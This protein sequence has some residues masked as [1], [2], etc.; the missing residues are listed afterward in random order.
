MTPSSV[1][2]PHLWRK[3]PGP[4]VIQAPFETAWKKVG[5]EG[6]K[7]EVTVFNSEIKIITS[8]EFLKSK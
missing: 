1:G 7:G 2:V 6:D 8:Q 5:A 3:D 4:S